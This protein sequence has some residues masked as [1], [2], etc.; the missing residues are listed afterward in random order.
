MPSTKRWAWPPG[1][2][3]AVVAAGIC[4]AGAKPALSG[5]AGA[6]KFGPTAQAASQPVA[7][8]HAPIRAV[9]SGSFFICQM[10]LLGRR[11]PLQFCNLANR[12]FRG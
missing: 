4:P 9:F 2:E 8:A 11:G 1:D 3:V 6:L 12:P 7:A 10:P 5:A